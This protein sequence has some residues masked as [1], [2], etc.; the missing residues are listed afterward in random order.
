MNKISIYALKFTYKLI[1]LN[2]VFLT[3]VMNTTIVELICI[4]VAVIRLIVYQ[5]GRNEARLQIFTQ[6]LIN[7][8]TFLNL[9]IRK[10][11]LH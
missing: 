7:D 1:A 5:Y 6:L 4:F 3:S 9:T 2:A 8:F 11:C 10:V